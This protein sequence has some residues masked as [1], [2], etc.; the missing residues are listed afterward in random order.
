MPIGLAQTAQATT[1]TITGVVT[2]E[3]SK[4]PIEGAQ[5]IPVGETVGTVTNVDGRYLLLNV[6]AGEH[7]I[8][9]VLLGFAQQSHTVTVTAGKTATTDFTLNASAVQLSRLVVSSIAG[10]ARLEWE[11]GAYDA[12][13]SSQQIRIRGGNRRSPSNEPVVYLDGVRMDYD[14][15]N[16]G[17]PSRLNDLERRDILSI[18][19]REG[20]AASELYGAAAANG[21]LVITTR[22]ESDRVDS[23]DREGY[24]SVEYN[25]FLT[26][27]A[28]LRS[29]FAID[30]DRASYS[31]VRRFLNHNRRPPPEAVRI[32]ELV[33]YFPYDYEEPR[34][35]HPFAVHTEVAPAPWNPDH[36]LVKIGIKGKSIAPESLP[37]SNLVFL[38][39][40][41]GSMGSPDKLPLL[42]SA[43]SLL[44]EELRPEDRIAMV[45]YAGAAGLVLEST[46]G[47]Q[48]ATILAALNRLSSGGST[49]GGAGIQL[50]Y[51]V[52][53]RN[54]IE[55]GNNRVILATDGDFNV[56][57]SSESDLRRLIEEKR[58]EGT[59]LTVL[60]FG[61]G[62]YQDAK[63]EQLAD[64]GNGNFA[65][66]DNLAEARKVLVTEMGGT[67][68]T[69]AKDVKIQVE[70][71]PKRVQAHRL[72]GY[73]NRMLAAEDFND[74]TK[75][76]GELG[77]GHTVTALYEIIPV[78]VDS[79]FAP[80][81]VDALRY[82]GM[83]VTGPAALTATTN[84]LQEW[85]GAVRAV[86]AAAIRFIRRSQ[87]ELMYVKLRYKQPDSD[88]SI[89]LS[90]AVYDDAAPA[91][92][93]LRFASAVAA[94]GM[95]LRGSPYCDADFD[96]VMA[97]AEEGLGADPEGYRAEFLSMVETARSLYR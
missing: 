64:H 8:R 18:E 67:L 59:F 24:A 95:I 9:V 44:I 52:A 5:V 3:V 27:A 61:T 47:D 65:Y 34:G 93:D 80:Q 1:G 41:S 11:R 20:Q 22:P 50:A 2:D 84:V 19:V 96:D 29:T 94:F 42:K 35:R 68:H 79:E 86:A 28:N 21:V 39:D 33:N 56:G 89:L 87:P 90:H 49:A 40:V 91:S 82:N 46:P 14:M 16:G 55:R 25:P 71:N 13:K 7:E 26:A 70:F 4:Q 37:P 85:Y 74:D 53:R 58:E 63:M 78:G 48:K 36:L 60:G 54:W 76:A 38:I 73:E 66:I 17:A 6:P 12:A 72:I 81:A 10:M 77:A 57:A 75:D 45:V 69:I 62:N 30:V 88:R 43:L 31:N 92:V 51:E 32:E 83:V 15:S 23:F 97:W